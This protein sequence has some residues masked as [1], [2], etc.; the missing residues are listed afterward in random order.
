MRPWS[1][2]NAQQLPTPRIHVLW[3][4]VCV[5]SV[6]S[7]PFRYAKFSIPNGEI[8]TLFRLMSASSLVHC[9][10]KHIQ[11]V[12]EWNN[13][14]IIRMQRR[15]NAFHLADGKT[16]QI[17]KKISFVKSHLSHTIPLLLINSSSGGNVNFSGCVWRHPY[18]LTLLSLWPFGYS[19]VPIYSHTI[20]IP[21]KKMRTI[22]G[23]F[24]CFHIQ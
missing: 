14:M 15:N 8:E 9:H 20:A 18:A 10:A 16:M 24:F 5:H 21:H 11:Y 4:D 23:E 22:Y 3:V 17:N 13:R 6:V 12:I 2:L 19:P 7:I 1:W